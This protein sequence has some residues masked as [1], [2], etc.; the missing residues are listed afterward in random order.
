M[1][2]Q[3]TSATTLEKSVIL[4]FNARLATHAAAFAASNPGATTY[5]YDSNTEVGYILDNY[6]QF[7]FVDN[8]SYG[9]VVLDCWC[10]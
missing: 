1:I 6:A 10:E 7:G 9:D 5:V 8:T 3:G 2:P 4:D